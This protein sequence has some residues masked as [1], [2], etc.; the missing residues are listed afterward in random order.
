M[1][2]SGRE[3]QCQKRGNIILGYLI[4]FS[5]PKKLVLYIRSLLSLK[6]VIKTKRLYCILSD[7]P[8]AIITEY[9]DLLSQGMEDK[10]LLLQEKENNSVI[11][12]G[13]AS[14][15]QEAKKRYL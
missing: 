1:V 14:E 7:C 13:N 8:T 4:V 11:C 12:D 10:D 6:L 9:M 2:T 3:Q 15:R 5:S